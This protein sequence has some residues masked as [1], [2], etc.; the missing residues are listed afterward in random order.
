M[1]LKKNAR[2]SAAG[3]PPG[4][5]VLQGVALDDGRHEPGIAAIERDGRRW[6]EIERGARLLTMSHQLVGRT[7][8]DPW[9]PDHARTA[10]AGG[11]D[12]AVL[13]E[14]AGQHVAVHRH[15]AKPAVRQ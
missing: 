4:D 7:R 2:F 9:R 3:A 8:A 13:L 15:V 12:D 11:V 5:T 1:P 6:P 14:D 10:E